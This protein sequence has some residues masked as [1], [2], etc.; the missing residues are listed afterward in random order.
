MGM[1]FVMANVDFT[2]TAENGFKK[3]EM[4][5]LAKGLPGNW[6]RPGLFEAYRQGIADDVFHPALHGLT[7]FCAPAVEYNLTEGG[8]REGLLRALWRA[9]TSYIYWRMPWV[10]YEYFNPEQPNAGFLSGET[11]K[12]SIRL[13][14]EAFAKFFKV[15]PDSACAPGFRANLATYEGW[16]KWGIHVAQRGSGAPQFPHFD[17]FGI[18][19]LH[20][21]IAF[22]LAQ[23]DLPI[24]KY[25]QLA[26]SCFSR[27]MPAVL[28]VDSINFHSSL[29]NFRDPTLQMLDVFL[30]AL[31][32]K[33][34]RLL[35]V[36]DADV[37]KVVTR[38]KFRTS[39]GL[40]SVPVK[41]EDAD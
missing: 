36:H 33:Y 37:Y 32:E 11:Q 4:Q 34:P 12:N 40:I 18:L 35:Y 19:N 6:K 7:H 9:E 27:G 8:E 1:N 26:D 29:T 15:F 5:A 25:L 2:K 22:D 39:Q 14:A 20:R 13:A 23:R 30:S 17:E 28:S 21:T 10:G 3:I 41:Q 38:G 24:E 31:E 16:A